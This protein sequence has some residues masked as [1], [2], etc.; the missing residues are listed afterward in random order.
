MLALEMRE[1]VA[2]LDDGLAREIADTLNLHF[3]GPLGL[4][5]DA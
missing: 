4:L 2:I 3:T 1:A 5:L